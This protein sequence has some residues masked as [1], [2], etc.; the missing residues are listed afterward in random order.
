MIPRP[1]RR[2]GRMGGYGDPAV[3]VASI[4]EYAAA[5]AKEHV[6]LEQ[7]AEVFGAIHRRRMDEAQA[8]ALRAAQIVWKMLRTPDTSLIVNYRKRRCGQPRSRSP[9]A[10]RARSPGR[11]TS[12]SDDDP[13]EPDRPRV[14]QRI[15]AE[16]AAATT[17][18]RCGAEALKDG[19]LRRCLGCEV[20]T[21]LRLV[22][23][24]S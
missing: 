21:Y 11:R 12:G 14:G 19:L 22:E 16:I 23:G 6:P 5:D 24:C 20:E 3:V 9:R 18:P 4:N 8:A 17:C 1:T 13:R 7:T 10:R 15:A 2:L